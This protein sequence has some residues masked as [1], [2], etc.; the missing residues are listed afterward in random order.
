MLFCTYE[1]KMMSLSKLC[2]FSLFVFAAHTHTHTLCTHITGTVVY[3]HTHTYAH[4]QRWKHTYILVSDIWR[5][6][7]DLVEQPCRR[8]WVR[9]GS[10]WTLDPHV[11]M[12]QQTNSPKP[13]QATFLSACHVIWILLLLDLKFIAFHRQ[14][15]TVQLL[16][17]SFGYDV[18]L[19]LVTE[20]TQGS[21]Q[22]KI[23]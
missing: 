3:T 22:V 7:L 18:R 6:H 17:T 8:W 14:L 9:Y 19:A 2:V 11:S 5:K 23:L 20:E 4:M 16:F 21:I 12:S 15:I 13:D 1:L 10:Q